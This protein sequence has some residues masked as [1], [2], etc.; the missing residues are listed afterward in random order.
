MERQCLITKLR[1]V[2][3]IPAQT[4]RSHLNKALLKETL[5]AERAQKQT[6]PEPPKQQGLIPIASHPETRD[7]I[8]P[9]ASF[10]ANILAEHYRPTLAFN[11]EQQEFYRYGSEFEGQ[12]SL[13]P[14]QFVRNMIGTE[15][16]AS[17]A[18]DLYSSGYIASV[19]DLIR[20][21]LAVRRWHETRTNL[22][23]MRNGV[24]EVATG[25]FLAHSPGY[26]FLWQLP[27]AYNPLATCQPFRIGYWRHKTAIRNGCNCS[28]PT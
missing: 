23:P 4:L 19:C 13:E 14:V 3:G 15:L 24:L 12:W 9:H 1:K 20:D 5:K 17:G 16:N 21:Q 28:E 2:T 7:P 27:Y 22:L 6:E 26:R 18:G 8:L 11:L 10:V 25:K